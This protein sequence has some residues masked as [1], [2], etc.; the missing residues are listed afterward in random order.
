[1]RSL[2]D[3][4]DDIRLRELVLFDR[5]AELGTLT[6]AARELQVPKPTASRWLAAL[7]ARIG[8]TL[9]VRGARRA[10]L[11]EQGRAFRQQ[12]QPVLVGV[13][14][15]RAAGRA[16][17]AGGTLRVSVP[18]PL[19]RLVGGPVIAEFKRRLP[20]VRLEVLL[21]NERVDLARDRIDLAI[22]AGPLPDSAWMARRLADIALW[23]YAGP[24][25]EP[26]AP[27]CLIAA[28]GDEALLSS[29]RP[30]LL[31]AAVVVDDRAVVRDALRAGAGVGIL[32]AFLG[33][34]LREA[35]ELVR[36]DELPLSNIRVHAVFAPEQRDDVRVR[37]LIELV[38]AELH[39]VIGLSW[40]AAVAGV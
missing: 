19:G 13:R 15:L 8:V 22:R 33:E 26:L 36:L 6:A 16:R 9:V 21:Q 37:V 14:A 10:G 40:S 5:L 35:G 12:L 23:L 11:T 30:D 4:F 1:M 25:V 39:R 20:A 7:E 3:D 29:R 17:Q 31:P 24:G 32:P 28:P 2:L 27:P 38:E 18:V 34:P